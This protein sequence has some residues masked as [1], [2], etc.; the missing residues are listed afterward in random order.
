MLRVDH[1]EIYRQAMIAA[2]RYVLVSGNSADHHMTETSM[3]TTIDNPGLARMRLARNQVLGMRQY[4]KDDGDYT[5]RAFQRYVRICRP[6][7]DLERRNFQAMVKVLTDARVTINFNAA[8][9]FTGECAYES[10]INCFERAAQGLAPPHSLKQRDQV[11]TRVFDYPGKDEYHAGRGAGRKPAQVR[12]QIQHY[13]ADWQRY[14]MMRPRY[15]A[16]DFGYCVNGGVGSDYY[17]KSLFILEDYVKAAS[18][19]SHTDSFFVEKDFRARRA[20]YGGVAPQAHQAIALFH[21]MPKLLYYCHP[22][23]LRQIYRY[24]SG[25]ATRGSERSLPG[26]LDGKLN[27]IECQM[28]TDVRFSRDV[29]GMVISHGDIQAAAAAYRNKGY[30]AYQMRKF[31]QRFAHRHGFPVRFVD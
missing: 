21:E 20:E 6:P 24:A 17:G 13:A 26:V 31:A 28:Q 27:Y 5:E 22:F 3:P 25:A 23:M 30:Q 15:G 16:L 4:L 9:F 29:R 11:E 14:P 18:S 19:Y 10:Y 2:R 1:F 12:M 7:R 8:T